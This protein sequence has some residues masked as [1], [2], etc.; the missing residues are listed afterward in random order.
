MRNAS[1]DIHAAVEVR[2]LLRHSLLQATLEHCMQIAAVPVW[3]FV[4]KAQKIGCVKHM[5]G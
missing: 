5:L 1:F 2:M 3:W 4:V